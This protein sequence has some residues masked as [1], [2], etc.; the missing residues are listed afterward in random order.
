M[1][2][3]GRPDAGSQLR[4]PLQT[5]EQERLAGPVI[6]VGIFPGDHL[7]GIE[8]ALRVDLAL[9]GE[10]HLVGLL[11]AALLQRVA[12]RVEDRAAIVLVDADDLVEPL[13][14]REAHQR[15]AGSADRAVEA[16]EFEMRRHLVAET[17]H[18]RLDVSEMIR[19][20]IARLQIGDRRI[21]ADG[22]QRRV[23]PGELV[24]RRQALEIRPP[25]RRE[26]RSRPCRA[27]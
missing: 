21:D 2:A 5:F 20:R 17:L 3:S 6:V 4:C 26:T 9:E 12:V 19:E 27:R 22:P 18:H 25:C 23:V 24:G 16:D 10:L 11:H 15:Q 7:A 14:R 13:L 8:Q 1:R